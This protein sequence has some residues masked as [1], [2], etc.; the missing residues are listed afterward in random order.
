MREKLIKRLIIY[1]YDEDNRRIMLEK[2]PMEYSTNCLNGPFVMEK[3]YELTGGDAV[4]VT[5]VGQHQMW[6]AQHY[7]YKNP[8]TLLTSGGLGTMGYGLGASIGAKLAK[9]E[10][11]VVNIA[12]DGC[13]R[14]NMNEIATATR[15]NIP[16]IQIV[17]NN[18]VL[19]MVRQWQTLFYGK[20][21]SNTTL[22]DSVDFVKISHHGSRNNT[23]N[24]LLDIIRCD[25]FIISTNGGKC[26]SNHPDRITIAHILCHPERNIDTKVHLYFN[27]KKELIEANG[28]AF[29]NDEEYKE[30][31][32]EIHD[33]ITEL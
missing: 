1:L 27:Y 18:H 30:W 25:K 14:M 33:N 19:G 15:Y 22:N 8:R 6:A 17:I 9:P 28:A 16:I 7:K 10:K 29:L 4:I 2:Y 20:R 26:R 11:T 24:S 5:D 31:N 12:G 3:I 23:S 32:F 13:F 21:Y